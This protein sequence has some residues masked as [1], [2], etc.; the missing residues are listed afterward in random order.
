MIKHLFIGIVCWIS[1]FSSLEGGEPKICLTLIVKNDA[2]QVDRCLNSVKDIVDCLCICDN[3]S[4]DGTRAIIEKFMLECDTPGKLYWSETIDGSYSKTLAIQ[5]AKKMVKEFGYLL[6]DTYFL[7][8][9]PDMVLQVASS[10]QKN[11]LS[12][13]AYLLAEQSSLGFATYAPHLF[14]ASLPWKSDSTVYEYWSAK[15]AGESIKLRTLVIEQQKNKDRLKRD[16]FHL[17]EDLSKEPDNSMNIFYLS[18][19]YRCLKQYEEAIQWYKVRIQKKEE[20]EEV[21]F[22]KYMIGECY[23]EREEWDHALYWY[24]EAYQQNP[25][26]A[27]SLKKIATY[28]RLRG[29]NDLA[30]IF[31][32]H[33]S[34]IPSPEDPVLLTNPPLNYQFDEEL[35]IAAYYTRFKEDGFTAANNVLLNRNVPWG[36]KAQTYR[37]ILFYVRNLP[38][39]RFHPIDVQ[40]PLIREGYDQRY[41]PMNPS[42]QKTENGYK[43]ICRT[44]NYTQMG[45]RSF[46]T[47]DA[48]GIFRTRNFLIEYDKDLKVISQQE[49]IENLPRER[50]PYNSILVGLDDC[51]IFNFNE[52]SWFTCTTGDT[53]QARNFQISLCKLE[54][55]TNSDTIQVEK[56]IPLIGPDPNRCEKNW[57]PFVKDGLFYVIYSYDPFVIYKPDIETGECETELRYSPTSDFSHVRG[58]AGPM[59]FDDGYL[60]VVHEIVSFEDYSRA[61]LHR[62]L[63]L[64]KNFNILQ[65]S[66]PF[67]FLH[68]G[69]EYCCSMVI[70]HSGHELVMALGIED[71]EAY[72][73]SIDLD[74]VKASLEPLHIISE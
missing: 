28:Y 58:S 38:N 5:T 63:Y 35:S 44:V 62:F 70:D 54:D 66:K 17:T 14:R 8:L 71:R 51:R 24:L 34:L 57:L 31:A 50:I 68:N 16:I 74:D 1:L 22:S 23:E 2:A 53:N 56:L 55:N 48:E 36:N 40:L 69:V 32:K 7:V 3:G 20:R 30:Y 9:D 64:D 39:T 60:V 46:N 4:T 72:L 29:Q 13:D 67:T 15:G 49:I 12:A 42:I 61:Y 21:W 10:F 52:S 18:Q 11:T 47:L 65:A 37:N 27:E 43:V 6:S 33:G 73:C 41:N 25:N 19:S 45:A 59:E 26:R